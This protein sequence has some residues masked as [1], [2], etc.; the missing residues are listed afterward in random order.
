VTGAPG[1]FDNGILERS[2]AEPLPTVQEA[3]VDGRPDQ[4]HLSSRSRAERMAYGKAARI[5]S[6]RSSHAAGTV[7]S[8]QRDPIA[9]LEEQA[10]TRVP[11]LVPIRYGRM[12]VSPFAYFRGAALPM[13]ADLATTPI[14]GLNV[15]LCGDAHLSNFGM[16]GSPERRLFF[17]V[18]DF[19]ETAPGPWEWDLK[20]L[21]ASLE[22]SGRENEFPGQQRRDIVGNAVRTYREAM[23]EFSEMPMLDVWYAH[24]DCDNLLPR[25]DALL[26]PK[27]TPNVWKAI[28]KARAHDSHQAFEKLVQLVDGEPRI[29]S[30]P[31]LIV[32][33]EQL[34][35][36]IHSDAG[37]RWLLGAV[38]SYQQTL[39]P[40]RRHLL[41]QYR[42]VHM[43]R[44]V[45]GVGSVGSDAW[46]T[47]LLDHGHA[48]PLFLQIKQAEAS[49][50]ER[51]TSKSR[52]SNHGERVVCGQ[53]MI[54]AAT[55]IFLGWVRDTRD[56]LIRDY[57]IRQ[58]R[59][60]K[61]SADIAGMRPSGMELWGQ[62]CGWT[63][64]RAHART[65]DR[66]AI[67]SYLG[68]SDKFDQA[69]VRYSGAY[70]DQIERD[71][72]TLQKAVRSGTL[73][74]DS[75]R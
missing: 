67:A 37:V 57:Y 72:A 51:F 64:A 9:L 4:A 40:D 38:R 73:V 16:F 20:R 2:E 50:L 1:L 18:N 6:P 35:E 53:R 60:W 34:G 13:A 39:Q 27:K 17:D 5:V 63:L 29:V 55:D 36:D 26:D 15:Q 71:F 23:T 31:P 11:E 61:G 12:L 8:E 7:A 3:V 21:A 44:K 66:I 70:A 65:G 52:F 32:P 14:T 30:D 42:F 10:T 47:L 19:D 58:L 25:F 54:Q 24:L 33:I 69:I 48:S 68:V 43:A 74:A 56:G 49:V 62:M 28:S 45:V 46:I 75:G 59:D 41:E 22:I